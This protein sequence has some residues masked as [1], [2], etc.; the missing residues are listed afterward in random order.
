MKKIYFAVVA[1]ALFVCCGTVSAQGQDFDE[2]NIVASFGVMS[3][4]HI[5]KPDNAPSVKFKS[6]LEQIVAKASEQ[7]PDGL[8]AMLF[9]G[10][11]IN[12]AYS[13]P[14]NYVQVDWFKAI[15]ES[16]LDPLKVPMIYTP[17]NHDVYKEWT[18]N[19]VKEARNISDRLGD[20]YFRTDLDNDI[21]I[22]KECRHCLVGGVHV[23]CVLPIGRNPVVYDPEVVEWLDSQL[24]EITTA[25]PE[26]YVLI[27]THPMITGTV[28]GSMLGDYWATEALT[29]VLEK[30]PQAV[31]FG[32]HLHFPLNDPRS[33]W[34]G[35]FTALGTASVRYMAIEDGQYEYMRSKT[36]MRD[37]DEYSQGL[38]L[39]IDGSGNIRLTRMD[40]FN[41]RTIGSPWVLSHPCADRSHLKTYSHKLRREANKAPRL[42]GLDATA[43]EGKITLNWAAGTD[44]EF[45]HHYQI[46]ITNKDTREVMLKKILT[47]FYRVRVPS[48]MKK[49]WTYEIGGLEKGRYTIELVAF[50]SWGASS[51]P[52]KT[53][54]TIPAK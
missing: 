31:T 41:K 5:E 22:A 10:D 16:V 28:Y 46:V 26:K 8:D 44:D 27:L 11:I 43:S 1:A 13:N 47:D 48:D 7:D 38:L 2:S 25:E 42:S 23:L 54:L 52:V 20:D 37:A 29:P 3:D 18:A 40:F 30:Y 33:I 51:K 6:A 19:D 35:D 49:D 50:D 15:Y 4:V 17:G 9:A 24:E 36:V 53:S 32:G 39:Q 45:V 21:R 12:N 34:Q 14:S